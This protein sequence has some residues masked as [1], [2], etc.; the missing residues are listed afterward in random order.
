M[1]VKS[2]KHAG[3]PALLACAA[4]ASCSKMPA[5]QDA[6]VSATVGPGSDTELCSG[7]ASTATFF[8]VG[9]TNSSNF[10]MTVPDGQ[11]ALSVNCTVT[12]SNGGYD[13]R[14]NANE[15]GSEGG[16]FTLTGHVTSSG[17]T[18][19]TAIFANPMQGD[20]SSSTCAVTYT[21]NR[22]MIAADQ[23]ISSGQIFGHVD[24]PAATNSNSQVTLSDGGAAM[25]TCDASADFLF[26]NCAE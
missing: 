16:A 1:M 22:S 15:S 17:G 23:T 25:T 3:W 12:P 6:F 11:G 8:A 7:V 10:P 26:Q 5:A 19:L 4:A 20:F 24:C 18:G 21:Y 14:L 2:L 13:I 9:Q